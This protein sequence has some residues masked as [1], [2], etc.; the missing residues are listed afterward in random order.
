[1]NK[2][3]AITYKIFYGNVEKKFN[4]LTDAENFIDEIW[5]KEYF[6]P[7]S[8]YGFCKLYNGKVIYQS[9]DWL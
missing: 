7:T 3:K 5:A 2:N 9:S 1:M 6:L 4:S 8:S